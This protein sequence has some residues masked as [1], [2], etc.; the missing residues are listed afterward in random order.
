MTERTSSYGKQARHGLV[1]GILTFVIL[2][3]AFIVCVLALPNAFLHFSQLLP[4]NYRYLAAEAIRTGDHQKAEAALQQRLSVAHYDFEALYLLAEVKAGSGNFREAVGVMQEV[5]NRV[6]SAS[7][8]PVGAT[9]F[10]ED[11]T[12]SSMARY[13]WLAGDHVSSA[14]MARAAVDA[15]APPLKEIQRS[16]VGTSV[17]LMADLSDIRPM[18]LQAFTLP[19]GARATT[20]VLHLGRNGE[21]VGH[22]NT[23]VY[24]VTTLVVR[25]TGSPALGMYPIL[26]LRSGE[27]ELARLYLDGLQPRNYE[28]RLWPDGAPK[29]LPLTI[30]FQND[31]F[32]PVTKS[33]RNVT[34]ELL[35]LY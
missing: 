6:R 15:G 9:G 16:A 35:A 4:E 19:A 32:D 24:K 10:Q 12:Y 13:L 27:R 20:E 23:G 7:G 30:S 5:F 26:V 34:V 14:E 8:R 29:T 2:C 33:D 1:P 11:R 18:D 21:A 3:T 25:A 17:P 31:A 22:F 28:L